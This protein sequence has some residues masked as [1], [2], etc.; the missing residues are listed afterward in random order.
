MRQIFFSH[1]VCLWHLVNPKCDKSYMYVHFYMCVRVPVCLVPVSVYFTYGACT[2]VHVLWSYWTS[3]E[4]F[5]SK[6][7]L[8][9]KRNTEHSSVVKE[10]FQ[11]CLKII[12]IFSVW[13]NKW[14]NLYKNQNN[15]FCHCNI[16]LE[17]SSVQ[18]NSASFMLCQGWR[19]FLLSKQLFCWCCCHFKS[20]LTSSM[21][22]LVSCCYPKS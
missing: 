15:C 11:T 21:Q 7:K 14:S 22:T 12:T 3:T 5:I 6:S 8:S 1:A 18:L 13:F 9:T 2:D 20:L 4:S 17:F 10:I 19:L 16:N